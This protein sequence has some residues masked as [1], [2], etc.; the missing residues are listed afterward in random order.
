M[1]IDQNFYFEN[2]VTYIAKTLLGKTLCTNINGV[3]TSAYIV[4]TEAYSVKEKGCHAYNY[5]KTNRTSI[6]F[7]KGGIAYIYL[8]YGIHNLF[9][10]VTNIEGE[11][12]A[13]LIRAIE[14]INGVETM[15][16]RRGLKG[17]ALTSGPGKLT[18]ALGIKHNHNGISL[19][20]D[21]IWI[22][23]GKKIDEIEIVSTT[24]IGIDYAEEDAFLPWRYYIR[25]NK[26]ISKL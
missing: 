14:P 9:N 4:E 10:V 20:S 11:P 19:L 25:G 21:N 7:Q 18:S 17:K 12:E 23:E 3:Q 8:C 6:M 2:D 16:Q 26:Y 24:R 5:K 22:E 15:E 13:V 1:R